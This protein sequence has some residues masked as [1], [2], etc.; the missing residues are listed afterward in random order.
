MLLAFVVYFSLIL[1]AE[2][3]VLKINLKPYPGLWENRAVINKIQLW[4]PLILIAIILGFRDG[5]GVDF[6]SYRYLYITQDQPDAFSEVPE[7]GFK[8][9][10]QLLNLIGL[11]F[12]IA[13]SVINIIAFYSV[14]RGIHDYPGKIWII[15][16]LFLTGQLFFFLN[17]TRQGLA[18]FVLVF[19]LNEY[20]K[21]NIWKFVILVGIAYSFHFS[22]IL[23]LIVPLLP[24]FKAILNFRFIIILSILIFS[25]FGSVIFG[26]IVNGIVEI[27]NHTHYARYGTLLF[28]WEMETGSGIG[29]LL[30]PLSAI[31]VFV[32]LRGFRKY[33][34]YRYDLLL[35]IYL[36]GTLMSLTFG[37]SLLLS[38]I[39]FLFISFQFI[40]FGLFINYLLSN[41]KILYHIEAYFFLFLYFSYYIGMI[42]LHNNGCSPY[43]F[44]F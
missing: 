41:N 12:P 11:P 40:V 16:F 17:I 34:K 42:L 43:K 29:A 25:I 15:L 44:C 3:P 18:L 19:A 39:V 9:I 30:Q 2:I 8:A 28:S 33:Y 13:L 21:H 5:V 14:Y 23:F 7:F 4:L 35:L 38:R 1:L 6:Y 37:N 31:L 27:M 20:C 36:T 10:Y 32:N 22:S 24:K 26:Y